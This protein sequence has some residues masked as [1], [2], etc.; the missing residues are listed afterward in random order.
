MF[1]R[2]FL[3]YFALNIK[4]Y[5]EK[6]LAKVQESFELGRHFVI[7]NAGADLFSALICDGIACFLAAFDSAK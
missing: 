6:L 5:N 1:I 4:G 3:N 7:Y 2:V